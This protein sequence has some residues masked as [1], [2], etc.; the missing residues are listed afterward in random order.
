MNHFRRSPPAQN[1]NNPPACIGV[2]IVSD[3]AFGAVTVVFP[4]THMFHSIGFRC[5]MELSSG[6]QTFS[7][8]SLLWISAIFR[9]IALL[10]H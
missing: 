7:H 6:G 2:G 9:T 1:A 10:F 4:L 5:G 3:Q 8:I